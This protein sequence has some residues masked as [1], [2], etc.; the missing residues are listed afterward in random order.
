MNHALSYRAWWTPADPKVHTLICP[1]VL[2]AAILLP[3]AGQTH[4][5]QPADSSFIRFFPAEHLF[6]RLTADGTAHQLGIAKDLQSRLW[7][8]TVGAQRPVMQL[9]LGSVDL[10]AGI[11]ATVQTSLIRKSPLLQVVTVDFFIDFPVD[12]RLSPSLTLRTGYG[13]HSAHLADDGIELLDIH[14][15]NYAK[16]YV[17]LAAAYA[18]PCI[19][20]FVY[21]GGRMDFH[22][23]PE[24]T[25]HWVLH[26]GSE[27]ARVSL[28]PSLT[29]YA[30][31]DFRFKEEN[32]WRSTQSYQIGMKLFS[33]PTGALRIAYTYRTG[34]DDRGQFYRQITDLSMLGVYL[35]L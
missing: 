32:A 29:L 15:L 16:D 33:S 30:A 21:G 25:S 17:S 4:A 28:L 5:Q 23:L 14:S 31:V 12:I 34:V 13:H 8:G 1:L 2:C 10:Q 19:R 35:D 22:S 9:S 20:G 11:G 3:V 18:L 27:F 7:V 24:T 26:W 6:P